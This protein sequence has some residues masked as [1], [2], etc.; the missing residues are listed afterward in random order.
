MQNLFF[1]TICRVGIFMICAQAMIHFRPQEAYEKYLKL[2]VSIMVM[3]QLFLP[4]GSFLLGGGGQQA[5]DMLEQ[6]KGELE[7]NMADAE[8]KAAEAEA[9]LEQM[10][11]AELRRRLEEQEN[12]AGEKAEAA[13]DSG[14]DRKAAG[15]TNGQAAARGLWA[16]KKG[17]RRPKIETGNGAMG[18]RASR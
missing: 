10:T 3:I 7:E 13:E 5:A 18:V 9:V 2:L 8:R 15:R 11:L 16:R 4:V 12:G 6:F 14:G 1:Q 17:R